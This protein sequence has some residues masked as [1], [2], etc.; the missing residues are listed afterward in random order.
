VKYNSNYS[1]PRKDLLRITASALMFVILCIQVAQVFHDHTQSKRIS[2]QQDKSTI[3]IDLPTCSICYYQSDK[4]GKQLNYAPETKFVFV[5][6][7]TET[8]TLL[9]ISRIPD[10]SLPGFTNKGPPAI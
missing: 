1:I 6:R 9:N 2:Y 10:L 3:D 5:S 7:E 8:N 4:Q